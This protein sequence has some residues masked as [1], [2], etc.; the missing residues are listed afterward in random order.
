MNKFFEGTWEEVAA[1]AEEFAGKH[2]RLTVIDEVPPAPQPNYAMLELLRRTEE[3]QRDMPFTDGSDTQRL[4]RE[5]RAGA[6]YG[7]EPIE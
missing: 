6:M 4:L 3:L 1:H 7:Y 2:V 5:A